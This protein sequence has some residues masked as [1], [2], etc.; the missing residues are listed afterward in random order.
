MT[1]CYTAESDK[2]G[3]NENET[4]ARPTAKKSTGSFYDTQQ[5]AMTV[6]F[7]GILQV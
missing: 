7:A 1:L 3:R 6:N 5:S 2:P 4:S